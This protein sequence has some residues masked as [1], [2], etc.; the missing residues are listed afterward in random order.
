MLI[1]SNN[2]SALAWQKGDGLL[3]CIVQDAYSGK[4][5]MQGFMNHESLE[6]TLTEKY[7]TFYSRSKQRLW[8]KGESSGHRLAMVQIEADCDRDS[9]LVLATPTGPTCHLGTDS[10]WPEHDVSAMTFIAELEQLLAG[11]KT[12]G[13]DGSYTARLY[14]KGIKRIAQ[15]VGEEG[16]ETALAATAGDIEELKQESADLLYH[17]LVLLQ[18]NDLSLQDVIDVLKHRQKN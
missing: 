4:V 17:L 18:A 9:L 8:M 14:A 13:S 15:K 5:L 10:C 1:D 11:R 3:P 2:I 7:V 16:V 6:K 12:A